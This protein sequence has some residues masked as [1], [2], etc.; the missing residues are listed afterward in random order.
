MTK[1]P[2]TV[3]LLLACT[4]GS[5]R[6]RLSGIFRYIHERAPNWTTVVRPFDS[7]A[8]PA[9]GYIVDGLHAGEFASIARERV[10]VVT[11]D[12]ESRSHS[13]LVAIDG[14]S[15]KCREET[16][17]TLRRAP[18]NIKVVKRSGN[19]YFTTLREK[20]MWGADVR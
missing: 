20:M 4:G 10:P 3:S 15:E 17:I 5:G 6:L 2:L 7:S 1:Y 18:Y 13:F 16:R 9:A 19:Q 12:V 14:R 11:L 8:L